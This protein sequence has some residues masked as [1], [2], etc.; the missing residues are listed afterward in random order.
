[1]LK[2]KILIKLSGKL[3]EQ[4]IF[5]E[6]AGDL[7]QLYQQDT[8]IILVHGGGKT[9]THYLNSQKI[10]S[11]FV[12]GLRVTT[13]E[14]VKIVEMVLAGLIN[15]QITRWLNHAGL[16]A[17]GLSGSD[18]KLIQ[19]EYMDER[20]GFVGKVSKISAELPQLLLENRK[21]VVIA[22]TGSSPDGSCL[23]INADSSAGALAAALQV[24]QLIFFTDTDGV[25]LDG[26]PLTILKSAEIS[27]F[28]ERGSARD[29]MIPKLIACRSAKENDVSKVNICAWAGKGTLLNL[30]ENK[31]AGTEIT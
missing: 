3:I 31:P 21:I 2:K 13:G 7:S 5:E 14:S 26:K 10:E 22:P 27:G 1:M 17:V 16:P 29:G 30:L 18:G 4:Q 12:D 24:N 23:N 11:E 6:L 20:L 15:K 8:A 19:A 25:L 9:I 28:I